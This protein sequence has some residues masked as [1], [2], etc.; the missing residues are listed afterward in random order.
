MMYLAH[1]VAIRGTIVAKPAVHGTTALATLECTS[2]KNK[3][4]W[5]QVTGRLLVRL[6]EFK[7]HQLY[8]GDQVL[9]ASDI[10]PIVSK[11]TLGAFDSKGFY[12]LQNMYTQANLRHID[13]IKI[14]ENNRYILTRW[15]QYCAEFCEKIIDKNITSSNEANISKA[16]LLGIRSEID[17]DLKKAY[18]NAGVI[19]VL[20]VSGLHVTLL[21]AIFQ[22]FFRRLMVSSRTGEIFS[23]CFLIVLLWA[24]AFI[25]GLSASVVRAVVMFTL[26][27]AAQ[28]L[29]K[30]SD[31]LNTVF[32]SAFVMLLYHAPYLF[33][34]G[35]QLSYLAVIGIVVIH[36]W[37]FEK[38]NLSN[39]FLEKI[40]EAT[41]ITL[42]AQLSTA[43]LCMYYFHQ[44]PTYFL[45][46]NLLIIFATNGVMILLIGLLT[47]SWFTPLASLCSWVTEWLLLLCNRYVALIDQLPLSTINSID[48]TGMQLLSLYVIILG[49]ALLISE[50]K[51]VYSYVCLGSAFLFLASA[52]HKDW[53][54]SLRKEVVIIGGN[55]LLIGV[56]NGNNF[57][58]PYTESQLSNTTKAQLSLHGIKYFNYGKAE[59]IPTV[60]YA[61]GFSIAYLKKNISI[62]KLITLHHSLSLDACYTSKLIKD[63]SNIYWLKHQPH[64]PYVQMHQIH[65]IP[66][67][68]LATDE[69]ITLP[70]LSKNKHL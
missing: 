65:R 58:F 52:I 28:L 68:S 62:K 24:F 67:I 42:A 11:K 5:H 41:S 50:K 32:V 59:Y 9:F 38:I 55:P 43:P 51:F 6:Q 2:A 34:V 29:G 35:F 15:S 46:A 64:Q 25:T 45:P 53:Q 63:R 33:D 19:H 13:L 23:I 61:Q 47:F 26:F 18:S 1:V 3:D 7:S 14:G 70:I 22:L 27:L 21:F 8:S 56:A 36:P 66:Y 30:R 57:Y 48:L 10:T 44:F 4:G 60:Q 31:M 17:K 49:L 12:G 40:A 16:L 20:A 69:I 39:S 54:T 37:W